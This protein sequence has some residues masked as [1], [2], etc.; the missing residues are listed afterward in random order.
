MKKM[1]SVLVQLGV[2]AGGAGCG[3]PPLDKIAPREV[4]D[5]PVTAARDLD[6]LFLVDD[7]PSMADKQNNLAAN[8]PRFIDVLSTLQGG[9]PNVHIGVATSDMGTHGEDG[10][11]GTAIPPLGMGGC[12]GFGKDGV[13]QVFGAASQINGLFISDLGLPDGTRERNYTGNLTDVFAQM[14]HAGASGCAFEQHL[15]AVKR[16]LTNPANTG[17]LRP[18]AYLG[19]IIIADEDDCSIE[20]ATLLANDPTSIST[21]GLQASFRCTRFGVACDQGGQTTDEMNQVGIK[22]QCHPNDNSAYLA[23]VSDY[24]TFLKSLKPNDPGKVIVAGIEGTIDP[25]EVELRGSTNP[26]P[27]LAHSCVY[28]GG[29]GQPEVADPPIRTKFF[30]DQFPN[31]STFQT[32][33]QQDLSGALQQIGELLKTALSDACIEGKL[34]DTDPKTPGP[35]YDCSVSVVV[36]QGQVNQTEQSLPLCTPEDATATNQPCWHLIVDEANCQ[37]LDLPK[38]LRD[39]LALKIEGLADLPSTG[40]VIASCTIVPTLGPAVSRQPR[41]DVRSGEGRSGLAVD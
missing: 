21:L 9:L 1:R 26:V 3:F 30:L 17:F 20:H 19:V 27:A 2:I 28:I 8:F 40:H 13:L 14:A 6:L 23:Q 39:H 7:S 29:D 12:S 38:N 24:A 22:N 18:D 31:R 35:Q 41:S 36:N 5:L 16:A 37:Q 33:C 32:I 11:I 4:K 15:S 34:A 10:Q 25:F